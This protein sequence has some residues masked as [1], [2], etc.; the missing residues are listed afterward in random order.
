MGPIRPLIATIA[1]LALAIF[2]SPALA[3]PAFPALTGRVVDAANV[4][5]P[6]AEARLDQK[7]AAL[8]AQSGRQLVVATLP[9]LQGYDIADYGYQLG[10]AWGIGD[11]ERNDGAL[12]IVAPG[13]RKLRIEVGYGLE[14]VLTD[15]MS[16]LI[17]NQTIVPKFKAG[18]LP[19][20]I[21]D[22]VD[23]IAQLLTL[24]PEE[25]AKIAAAAEA[26][27]ANGPDW[28]TIIFFGVVFLVFILPMLSRKG[29]R[30]YRS[31]GFAPVIW[32]TGGGFGSGSRG[33]GGG[34]GGGFGGGFSGGGGSFGGGGSSGRW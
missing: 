34:L 22:G 3:A 30:R 14:G 19:G 29:G 16:S 20:G 24:P 8:E 13:E 18:D 31:G 1:A 21:E 6:D 4:I 26:T 32:P 27:P 28:G 33:F 7:L 23:R 9:D 5:P 25:A 15:G 11:K 2:A 10:R 17:I 12:L